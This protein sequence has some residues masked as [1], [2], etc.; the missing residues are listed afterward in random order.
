MAAWKN[1]IVFDIDGTIAFN[2][3]PVEESIC[4]AIQ[5]KKAEGFDIIFAT[6]RPARDALPL[7]PK[8]LHDE[9]I[10][11]CNGAV[12]SKKGRILSHVHFNDSASNSIFNFLNKNNIPYVIDGVEKYSISATHHEFHCYIEK[13]SC[14]PVCYEEVLAEKLTKFLIL[15]KSYQKS[16]IEFVS[17]AGIRCNINYHKKDDIFDLVPDEVNKFNA[18]RK[19][20]IEEKSYICFGNDKNDALILEN[21]RS[22]N[23]VGNELISANATYLLPNEVSSRILEVM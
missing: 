23:V 7:L 14:P 16:I 11:A 20:G 22:A 3:A 19:L 1:T 17:E 13:L 5:K 21:A 15:D 2:G 8:Y 18:L 6:A 9:T 12:T 10:I 4:L